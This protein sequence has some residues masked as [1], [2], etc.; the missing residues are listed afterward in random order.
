MCEIHYIYIYI[1]YDG[2][3]QHPIYKINYINIQH[4]YNIYANIY[5]L[6]IQ[7]ATYIVIMLHLNIVIRLVDIIWLNVNILM[8]HVNTI[9]LHVITIYLAYWG[10]LLSP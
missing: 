10:R 6:F 8:S 3:I 7:H 4:I 2:P 9:M 5:D 1:Q